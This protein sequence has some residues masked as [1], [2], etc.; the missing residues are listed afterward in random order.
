MKPL[1]GQ[2]LRQRVASAVQ[3]TLDRLHGD[4][5]P[6]C[7]LL[8]G[9]GAPFPQDQCRTKLRTDLSQRFL[10]RADLRQPFAEVSNCQTFQK[11]FRQGVSTTPDDLEGS[12]GCNPVE[13]GGEPGPSGERAEVSPRC[14]GGVLEGI[15][16]V[17][18]VATDPV[19]DCPRSRPTALEKFSESHFV[20]EHG[21]AHQIRIA[22][23][24][25]PFVV[26]STSLSGPER[27]GPAKHWATA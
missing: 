25:Q 22:Y 26:P 10:H 23:H 27:R 7:D 4:A 12:V 8:I 3:P 1:L 11:V 2:Q 16:G 6:F 20:P 24:C 5:L 19:A 9:Q 18:A 17:V 21:T 14:Y 15:L 13:P